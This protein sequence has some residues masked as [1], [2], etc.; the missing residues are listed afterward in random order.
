LKPT[1][2]KQTA[3]TTK[4]NLISKDAVYYREFLNEL[5]TSLRT[6]AIA[7]MGIVSKSLPHDPMW[8]GQN[9]FEHF[10]NDMGLRPENTILI[11]KNK[12]KIFC[13]SNCMWMNW[14]EYSYLNKKIPASRF[15]HCRIIRVEE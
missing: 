13:K 14:R 10:H 3:R 11:R 2:D 6:T 12:N 15:T 8:A 1:I 9:G 7:W 4:I 5:P